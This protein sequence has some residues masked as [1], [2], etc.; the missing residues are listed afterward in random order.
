MRGASHVRQIV[1]FALDNINVPAK[2]GGFK[3]KDES[4]ELAGEGL[5]LQ[6]SAAEFISAWMTRGRGLC[7]GNEL[8]YAG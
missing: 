5:A 3:T 2:C 6:D 4:A 1:T 7:L 8:R